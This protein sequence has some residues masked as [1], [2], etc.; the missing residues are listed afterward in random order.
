MVAFFFF[1]SKLGVCQ[2]YSIT[3]KS[4]WLGNN[5]RNNS[6]CT[7]KS[8]LIIKFERKL[9]AWYDFASVDSNIIYLVALCLAFLNKLVVGKILEVEAN[10]L[11]KKFFRKCIS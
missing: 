6:L 11:I 7:R 1:S 4:V 8:I 9:W 2:V 5:D 3:V 10:L